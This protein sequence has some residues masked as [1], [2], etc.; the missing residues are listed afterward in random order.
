MIEETTENLRQ[1]LMINQFTMA[2][3]C[4]AEQARQLLQSTRWEFEVKSNLFRQT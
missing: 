2:T 4:T 3:G 1:Q